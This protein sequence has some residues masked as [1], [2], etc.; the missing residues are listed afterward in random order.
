MDFIREMPK[1]ELHYH[2]DGGM[3]P[4]TVADIAKSEGIDLPAKTAD[5]LRPYLTVG[6]ECESL[7]EYLQKFDLPLRCLQSAAA[8][9]RAAKEAVEDAAACNVRYIEVRFAPNL[10]TEGGLSVT[11]VVKNVVD[12]LAD[13]ERGTGTRAR[14]ILCLMRHQGADLDSA[15]IGAAKAFFGKGVAGVDLAGDEA[16]FSALIHREAFK[17]ARAAGIPVTIHA[18]EAGGADNVREAVEELG[19]E[20]IGHGIRLREEP[21]VKEL[22]KNRGT[23][24]EICITSNV[25][26]RAASSL[27]AH[28]V[29][30]YFDAGLKV[31]VNTDNTTV[32]NTDLCREFSILESQFRFTHEELR[33]LVE[34]AADAAFLEQPQKSELI[35]RIAR[36]FDALG[37]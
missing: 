4:Q 10:M 14:A 36:E 16:G 17:A 23:A 20:R 25:Q 2:L 3:R 1:I 12:G 19:A 9:R 28:P 34:N 15:V 29:R 8:Q 7:V 31:T 11:D 37:N 24:L 35:A 21:G 30:E 26:T 33:R 27:A 18:G 32:S 13:G 22:V 5:G 6:G